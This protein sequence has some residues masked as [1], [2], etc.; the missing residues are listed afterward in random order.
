MAANT[1]NK[2]FGVEM[3]YIPEGPFYAGD[4]NSTSTARFKEGSSD[5]DPWYIQAESAF[6]TTA[7]ASNGFY[8][9]SGGA[10]GE[11]ATGTVFLIPSSFPKGYKAFYLMKYE[12]TEGQWVSFFNTLSTSAKTNRD[13]TSAV[14]G[15]KSSDSVVTRNTVSWNSSLPTS[16][17]TTSRPDRPV[18]YISWPDFCAYID[19]AGL[20]PFTELEFEKA[21]R[22]TDIFPVVNE[23]AWGKTTFNPAQANEIFPDADEDGSEQIFDGASNI[24]SNA[25]SWTTGDGRSGG[26]AQGQAGPLRVGIFAESSTNRATAGAGFYGNMELSGNLSEMIVTIGKQKGRQFLGTHGDGELAN[27]TGYEGNATNTD[28]PGMNTTDTA[29][30]ITG[31]EG[32][33]YRGGDFQTADATIY[34]ISTRTNAAKDADG[35]GYNQRYDGSAAIYA[36]GR[37]ARTAP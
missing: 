19:W 1:I 32:S 8:Y 10:S 34:Q 18:S 25:L 21:T 20:R 4:G 35:Q 16:D 6:S 30:G 26:A 23:Y 3:V 15:G 37:A 13:I 17:A 2:V 27:L 12:L 31:T 7:G 36:G 11:E 14:E 33:G 9:T 5:D 24:N 22:G 28:W 29:R